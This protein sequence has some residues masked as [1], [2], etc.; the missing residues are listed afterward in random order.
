[1]IAH[2]NPSVLFHRPIDSRNHIPNFARLIVH[3]GFQTDAHVIG[4]ADVIRK[5]KRALKTFRARR[6]FQR[7]DQFARLIVSERLHRN[8]RNVFVSFFQA[9]SLYTGRCGLARRQRIAGI[10]KQ[11]LD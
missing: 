1:M 2:H 6:S 10:M 7:L 4:A 8:A 11:K 3:V 9:E 5:R